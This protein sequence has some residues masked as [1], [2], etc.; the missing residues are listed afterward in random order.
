M[1]INARAYQFCGPRNRSRVV[2]HSGLVVAAGF[3]SESNGRHCSWAI[4]D[5]VDNQC[6]SRPYIGQPLVADNSKATRACML[7]STPHAHIENGTAVTGRIVHRACDTYRTIYVP[8]DSS[9]RKALIVHENIPHNHPM[10]VLKKASF[11][12]KETYRG[13]PESLDPAQPQN[14]C[15]VGVALQDKKLKQWLVREV[16]M[17]QYPAGLDAAG[18]FKLFWDDMEKGPD[19][20]YIHRPVM[21][22]DGEWNTKGLQ[23]SLGRQRTDK[24]GTKDRQHLLGGENPACPLS[25]LC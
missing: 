25:P 22:P 7:L 6:L 10:P 14:A 18:A 24:G 17:E 8:V 16:K 19:E 21:M 2:K 11:K 5:D 1:S 9:I 13:V 23:R 20:K 12:L 3:S 15:E 4:P